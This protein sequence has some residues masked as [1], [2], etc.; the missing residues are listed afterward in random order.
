MKTSAI[1]IVTAF[2]TFGLTIL[3]MA[4]GF[5]DQLEAALNACGGPR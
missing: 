5:A 2:V 4:A 1:V 3:F